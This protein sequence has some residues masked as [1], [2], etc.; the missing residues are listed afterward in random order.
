MPYLSKASKTLISEIIS[1][2][3]K[4]TGIVISPSQAVEAMHKSWRKE[5]EDTEW[6]L[7]GDEKQ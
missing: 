1:T 5:L 2:Y 7:P 3:K 6:V 4:N